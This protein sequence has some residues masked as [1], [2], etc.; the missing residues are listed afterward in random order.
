MINSAV[1][2]KLGKNDPVE[3]HRV[4]TKTEIKKIVKYCDD[5]GDIILKTIIYLVY[6]E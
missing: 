1:G 2:I 5:K 4:Y 6:G 3:R